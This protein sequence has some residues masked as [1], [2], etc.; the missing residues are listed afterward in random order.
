MAKVDYAASAAQIVE[1]VGGTNNISKV[2]HCVTRVRF[3]L[4]DDAVAHDNVEAVKA[5]PGVIQVVEQGGQYQVVIGTTVEK[6]YDEVVAIT[7]NAGGEVAADE[8]QDPNEGEKLSIFQRFIKMISNIMIPCLG[9]MIGCGII[10]SLG[11]ILMVTGICGFES[12]TYTFLT[13]L[14]QT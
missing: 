8:G 13:G 5:V 9:A 14:G 11:T 3:V 4:K 12:D 6:M 10:S 2:T 7:G 1:L